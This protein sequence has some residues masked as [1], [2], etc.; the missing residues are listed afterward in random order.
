[1]KNKRLLILL[2][3]TSVCFGFSRQAAQ[4]N[5]KPPKKQFPCGVPLNRINH[6]K[7]NDKGL[8]MVFNP[9]FKWKKKEL[10]VYFTDIEDLDLMEKTLNIANRW[11][12]EAGAKIK[13]VLTA[14]ITE[15]DIRIA[16]KD[17][18]GYQSVIGNEADLIEYASATTMSL[19][20]LNSTPDAEFN[21]V[22]LH[23]FGHAIGL[24]HELQSPNAH[25]VWDTAAVYKFYR[26]TYSWDSAKVNFN[27]F[28]KINTAEATVFDP[29]SIM[30]YAVPAF[31]VKN[32][33]EIPWPDKLSAL[34]K[35]TIKKYYP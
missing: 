30:I 6:Y 24:E 26:E 27:V 18:N 28:G 31:L 3:F 4:K 16:F 33:I 21:R 10:K 32:N 7:K 23:E 2:L 12:T 14:S 34:D 9:P 5:T 19:Q 8:E 20:N 17:K 11:S 13:F 25:I 22:V 1:M 29:Q 35:K 15:S